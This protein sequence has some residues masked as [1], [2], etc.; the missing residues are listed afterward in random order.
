MN[1]GRQ[2]AAA[3]ALAIVL[4]AS[5][6]V[7]FISGNE[8]LTVEASDGSVSSAALS[9]AGYERARSETMTV[10][11]TFEVAG[12][13]REVQAKNHLSEYH[14]TVSLP[15]LGG[16]RKAAVFV[17][18]TTP[19]V[20][21][22]GQTFNPVGEM[23]N[24]ELLDELQSQYDDIEVGQRTDSRTVR[25]LGTDA[26]VD[27]FE[28]SARLSGVSLDVRFQ[29]TKIRHGDDFVIAV[30]IYPKQLPGEGENV[31]TLLRNLQHAE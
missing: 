23:S 12:Q 30:G 21:F 4:V 19:Q 18:F 11:R 28:G 16:E 8:A 22:A 20:E 7:G 1:D 27:T 29:I 26:T 10:E 31:D 15:V 24:R 5:G 13:T 25:T 2:A 3:T 14:K 17:V 9:D 6:C